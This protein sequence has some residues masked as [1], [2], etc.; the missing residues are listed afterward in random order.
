M[1]TSQTFMKKINILTEVES[2]HLLT[3]DADC[4]RRKY[5]PIKIFISLATIKVQ[6]QL[7][8]LCNHSEIPADMQVVTSG[9]K[10][11]MQKSS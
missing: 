6:F 11:N 9:T 1:T 3:V 10:K 8:Q 5:I 4:R 7:I 2:F